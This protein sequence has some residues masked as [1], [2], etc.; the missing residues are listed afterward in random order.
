MEEKM[1]LLS[2]ILFIPLCL[3]FED[4][5]SGSSD[6]QEKLEER[7]HQ[8]L[9]RAIKYGHYQDDDDFPY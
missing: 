9:I 4:A 8:E 2:L 6:F 5:F 3:Y 7:R 1:F